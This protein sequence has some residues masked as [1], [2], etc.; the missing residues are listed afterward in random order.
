M[1]EIIDFG[2]FILVLCSS[3]VIIPYLIEWIIDIIIGIIINKK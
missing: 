3:I 1:L 2:L